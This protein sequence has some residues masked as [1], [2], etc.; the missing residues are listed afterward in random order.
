MRKVSRSPYTVMS[1][2]SGA[3]TLGRIIGRIALVRM[4]TSNPLDKASPAWFW[5]YLPNL[6]FAKEGQFIGP[7]HLHATLTETL[8]GA[9]ATYLYAR[10]QAGGWEAVLGAVRNPLPSTEQLLHPSKVD[11]DFPVNV[12][13]PDWPEDEYGDENPF[14]KVTMVYEDVLGEQTIHYLLLERGV[15]PLQARLAAI[16]WDGDRMRIY[17]HE[18]GQRI[19]VWRSVWDRDVDAEQFATAIAPKGIEP[20]AFRV[21]RHGRVVD[22]FN[23]NQSAK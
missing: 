6:L 2:V 17:D 16:G 5:T 19:V 1:E 18:N 23:D 22:A 11:Q 9:G 4:R 3:C 20:R 13:V 12:A 14:G 21:E 10:Y 7:Q 8:C 15:E